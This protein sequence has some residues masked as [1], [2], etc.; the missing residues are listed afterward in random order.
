MLFF[1]P[2]SSPLGVSKVHLFKPGETFP[3]HTYITVFSFE[4]SQVY[5]YKLAWTL[6][7]FHLLVFRL[8]NP[9]ERPAGHAEP[10][11]NHGANPPPARLRQ[12][13]PGQR[14]R[15]LEPY[16]RHSRLLEGGRS[17]L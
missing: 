12:H 9:L 13:G 17:D 15:A 5:S 14:V 1:K 16:Q 10:A 11:A 8:Q 3:A 6:F 4:A 7:L 2:R